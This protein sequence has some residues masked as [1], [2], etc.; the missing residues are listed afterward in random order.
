[1]VRGADHKDMDPDR[2][3]GADPPAGAVDGDPPTVDEAVRKFLEAR[4]A[5]FRGRCVKPDQ[6]ARGQDEP[7]A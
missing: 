7:T 2:P 4:E 1:M 5:Y 3:N 6:G